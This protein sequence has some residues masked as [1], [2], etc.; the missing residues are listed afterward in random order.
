MSATLISLVRNS[1]LSEIAPSVGQ[2]EEVF[3]NKFN[4]PWT[5]FNDEE[6]K[7]ILESKIQKAAGNSNCTFITIDKEDW[8]EPE[9]INTTLALELGKQMREVDVIQ[10]ADMPS[11]HRMCRWN[12]GKFFDPPEM[13]QYGYYWRVEPKTKY[14]CEIDYDVF[15]YMDTYDKDYGFVINLYDAPQ[16]VRSLWPT[17]QKFF[18]Q[19][20]EYIHPNNALQWL[21]QESRPDHNA[22]ANGYSTCHFWSNF[23]IGRL[24]FFRSQPYRDYFDHLDRSGGFFYERWG[25]APVHSISLAMMTDKSRIHWFQDIGYE[26]PPYYNCPTSGKCKKCEPG[27]FSMYDSLEPENCMPEWFKV[28]GAAK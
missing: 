20:P 9:Y 8:M 14:F 6:F 1:E 23:E 26:H 5:F 7:M 22:L 21:T 4:Y 15:A 27:K 12:S 13:Q 10:Y 24:D 28:A 11:Y 25:D 18:Q 2:I 3:N 16:S 17:V 19:H